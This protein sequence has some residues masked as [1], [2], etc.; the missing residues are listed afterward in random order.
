MQGC[1][2][3]DRIPFFDTCTTSESFPTNIALL[4]LLEERSQPKYDICP[5][6]EDPL[7]LICLVDGAKVCRYC[8]DF[9]GHKSHRVMHMNDM[10][11]EARQK[12]ERLE[13]ILQ[14][15]ETF[16]QYSNDLL[17]ITRIELLAKTKKKFDVFREMITEKENSVCLSIENFF[18]QEKVRMLSRFEK[19]STAVE[20]IKEMILA[21]NK[22]D[23]DWEFLEALEAEERDE[24]G[25]QLEQEVFK[26]RMQKAKQKLEKPLKNLTDALQAII[27]D[28]TPTFPKAETETA[29]MKSVLNNDDLS[30]K[31]IMT[32]PP[33]PVL[34]GGRMNGKKEE[35]LK[36]SYGKFRILQSIEL[37]VQDNL[38]IISSRQTDRNYNKPDPITLSS[39]ELQKVNQVT[40]NSDGWRFSEDVVPVV[41]HIWKNLGEVTSLQINLV[42][43]YLTDAGLDGLCSRPFWASKSLQAFELDIYGGNVGDQSVMKLMGEA[44]VRMANLKDL[45]IR[46]SETKITD[47][48]IYMLADVV[49]PSMSGLKHFDLR[50]AG[51]QVTDRSIEPLCLRAKIVLKSAVSLTLALTNTKITDKVLRRLI[52]M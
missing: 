23:T 15:Y 34:L 14:G 10:Q 47:K 7:N 12:V 42:S 27:D 33:E 3:L 2:P 31:K 26:R 39:E 41:A 1:C 17:E 32:Q 48:S 18:E 44:M 37:R 5:L 46:L 13:E 28:F 49:F 19:N 24:I 25:N 40:I 52:L 35:R 4:Q 11:S 45:K 29:M 6:H 20:E 22:E 8:V 30:L 9:G 51:T 43:K 21:L 50:I 36:G 16:Q 38:L